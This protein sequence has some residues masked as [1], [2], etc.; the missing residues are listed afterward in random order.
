VV[1]PTFHY[2]DLSGA[3]ANAIKPKAGQQFLQECSQLGTLEF[4]EVKRVSGGPYSNIYLTKIETGWTGASWKV[5]VKA[6]GSNGLR[7][8]P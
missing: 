1:C 8:T 5:S 4:D 3:V 7:Q 2:P 6:S